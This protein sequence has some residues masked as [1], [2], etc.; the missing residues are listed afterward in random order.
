MT[1]VRMADLNLEDIS[2]DQF[3][4]LETSQVAGLVL[5]FLQTGYAG[6][7]NNHPGNLGITISRNYGRREAEVKSRVFSASRWL[8]NHDYLEEIND[9]G[10][11]KL[12]KKGGKPEAVKELLAAESA[13]IGSQ[14]E[15]PKPR[16]AQKPLGDALDIFISH[17]SQDIDI[18]ESLINLL[19]AALNTPA[20][21]IRCTSVPG[22]RLRGGASTDETLRDEVHSSTVLVGLITSASL[23]SAYVLFELGARWGAGRYMVPLLARGTEPSVL[24]G[25]L[26]GISALRT[27]DA[28]DLHQ[29]VDNIASELRLPRPYAPAYQRQ[30]DALVQISSAAEVIPA[31]A[32]PT[33]RQVD[34]S[35][36]AEEILLAAE[37]GGGDML[38]SSMDQGT[39]LRAGTRTFG[40]EADPAVAAVYRDALEELIGAGF[41]K[42][43]NEEFFELTGKGFKAARELNRRSAI[44]TR[45]SANTTLS[46]SDELLHAII[47]HVPETVS[48]GNEPHQLIIGLVNN[49]LKTLTDYRVEVEIPRAVLNPSTSFGA[50]E[51]ESRSTWEHRFFRMEG[52][53]HRDQ[54]LRPGD[55]I[56]Q[57]FKPMLII[58]PEA[59]S[60]NALDQKITVSVFNGDVLTQKIEKT[61]REIFEQQPSFG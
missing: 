39:F 2:V 56:K 21:R 3:I 46:T 5:K 14:S 35:E 43:D 18:A 27:Y 26:T 33:R 60:S 24:R 17:S 54:T 7:V 19:R 10:F 55:K 20:E 12:S 15:A 61:V 48:G 6:T 23:S 50:T 31:R 36:E 58:T 51:V 29:L 40:D 13:D 44:D 8:L 9:Q 22:Y 34:L 49:S 37:A 59:K 45:D 25:P 28:A 52:K 38:I 42:T 16:G 32:T 53:H 41:V 4:D 1:G 57:F 47:N 30:L 11:F